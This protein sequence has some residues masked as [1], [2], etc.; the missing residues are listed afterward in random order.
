MRGLSVPLVFAGAT[1]C[2]LDFPEASWELWH[3]ISRAWMFVDGGYW[4]ISGRVKS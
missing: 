2:G 1:V 3:Q 4:M